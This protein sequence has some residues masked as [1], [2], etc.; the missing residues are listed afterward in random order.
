MPRRVWVEIIP[1]SM[2]LIGAVAPTAAAQTPAS[3]SASQHRAELGRVNDE[4]RSW[5]VS[6]AAVPTGADAED[7]VL[8]NKIVVGVKPDKMM[9][10][11]F[12]SFDGNWQR[13]PFQRRMT[14]SGTHAVIEWPMS[15]AVQFVEMPSVA[16]P[17]QAQ[18]E[19]L[20][21]A[22][23]WWPLSAGKP[24]EYLSGAKTVWSEVSNDATYVVKPLQESVEGVPC[25]VL[26]SPAG[27]TMWI[28]PL[29]PG[30]MLAREYAEPSG[31][32]RLQRL[33]LRGHHLVGDR[34]WVPAEM[35]NLQ[36][37][38]PDGKIEDE[39]LASRIVLTSVRI[40]D[41]R[42]DLSVGY[43]LPL[44]TIAIA[45]DG[46][47]TQ[48]VPDG[49]DHLE[50]MAEWLREFSGG[51]SRHGRWIDVLCGLAVGITGGACVWI[52]GGLTLGV[53]FSR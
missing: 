14:M 16:F 4:I 2:L 21:I 22:L 15:R 25:D 44:G 24:P 32:R 37:L 9:Q 30:C 49:Q 43:T 27:D 7:R 28:D 51:S 8:V 18:E 45:G 47:Y 17:P 3:K 41:P 35:D 20:F 36:Y 33:V 26:Q 34:V 5:S 39:P 42:D 12:K 10:W 50:S 53:V 31:G 29:R 52:V 46:T 6:Y 23:G 11:V 38:R 19:L 13:D 1:A 48:I 40:N